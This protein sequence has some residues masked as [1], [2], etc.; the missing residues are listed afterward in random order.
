MFSGSVLL[1]GTEGWRALVRGLAAMLTSSFLRF[2]VIQNNIVLKK[3]SSKFQGYDFL[4][5]PRS[6]SHPLEQKT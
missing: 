2:S 6:P 1:L 4:L 3:V 5:M